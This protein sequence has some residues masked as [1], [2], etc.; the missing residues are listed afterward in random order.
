[1]QVDFEGCEVKKLF[2]QGSQFEFSDYK[3]DDQVKSI[4]EAKGITKLYKHQAQALQ[5]IEK[6][7][8]LVISSPTA[9]G[10]SEV[11]IIPV[12]KA[13]LSGKTSL[14]LFPTKALSRDQLQRFRDFSLYGLRCEVYDG[15]TTQTKRKN[16]K[17][18]TP[19]VLITNIDMLN[20]ILMNNR[21]F[22]KFFKNLKYIVIDEVHTYTGVFGS[23]SGNILK[24]L[25]RVAKLHGNNQN[26]Q[27]I[28]SS[29]TIAN[30]KS[31]CELLTSKPFEQINL[32]SI[33]KSN[34]EHYLI[35]PYSKSYVSCALDV[36]SVIQKSNKKTLVFADSH[37]LVERLGLHA[38]K[39][40]NVEVYRGG[41]KFKERKR[42]EDDFK[43]GKVKILITTSALELGIDIGDIDSVVLVGWPGTITRKKQRIGRAGRRT[44]NAHAY[45]IARMNALD[46]YYFEHD[47]EYL[48]GEPEN[49]Y[50]NINNSKIRK[51]HL[52]L[53]AKDHFIS[54]DELNEQEKI[55]LRELI[56]QGLIEE[57]KAGIYGVTYEGAITARKINIRNIGDSVQIIS[58]G[59]VIGTRDFSSAIS[60]LHKG[61]IYLLGAQRYLSLGL[62]PI[63][64]KAYVKKMDNNSF[65]YTKPIREK[66][67]ELIEVI[68]QRKA[69]SRDL[70]FGKIH[71]KEQVIGYSYHDG[72]TSK[73]IDKKYL[74]EPLEFEFETYGLYFDTSDLIFSIQD[75][76]SGLHAFEHMTI[77]MIPAITGSDPREVGGI[78]YS[79]GDLII[80]DGI[81]DGNGVTDVVFNKFEKI[82]EMAKNAITSCS[83]KDGCPKCV[84]D[85]LCG[86]SNMYINKQAGIDI[87]NSLFD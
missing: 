11:Y 66:E 14:I 67:S 43:K 51:K 84:L 41:L 77:S 74:E 47:D 83:C 6:G 3:L 18:I 50:V 49:S 78:S 81:P 28:A 53:M 19:H 85:P 4:L 42:I 22:S 36:I 62:D 15:D 44:G 86:N 69:F 26:I 60:E 10:K 9:T 65:D 72:L 48:N 87:F 35:F 58:N 79:N 33:N 73:I 76:A 56:E 70:K 23:H 71:I 8:N 29:A 54:K 24:R 52:L 13:G 75:F 30:P 63:Q 82:V 32:N 57:K 25:F 55:M 2:E 46:Y 39:Y 20:F 34:I 61:A 59:N 7:K 1:M 45:F 80:Y 21:A 38:K 5:I 16:I 37:Q 40:A 17:L 68:K 64:K 31:F 12:F 27:I